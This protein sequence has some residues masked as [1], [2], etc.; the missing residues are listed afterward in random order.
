[1]FSFQIAI[2]N[3]KYQNVLGLPLNNFPICIFG[4]TVL[5][6]MISIKK[7]HEI[8]HSTIN[9]LFPLCQRLAVQDVLMQNDIAHQLSQSEVSYWVTIQDVTVKRDNFLMLES[10]RIHSSRHRRQ[11]A[12]CRLIHGTCRGKLVGGGKGRT[13][14]DDD[15]RG[16][17]PWL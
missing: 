17:F 13:V 6:L 8:N 4:Q 11:R 12:L 5:K 7:R 3:W 16:C 15:R 9:H 14:Q 10:L 1:M 2:K